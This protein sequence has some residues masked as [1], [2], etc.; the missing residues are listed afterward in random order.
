MF[1][2]LSSNRSCRLPHTTTLVFYIS[3][4]VI[5]FVNELSHLGQVI[6]TSDDEM[7]DIE[8]RKSSPT[9]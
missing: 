2:A 3:D 7:H 4:N 5:E 6:S 1:I 8:S 9:G